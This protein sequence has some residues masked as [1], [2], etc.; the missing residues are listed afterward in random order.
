MVGMDC[1]KRRIVALRRQTH[2]G[3][4]A[5]RGIESEDINAFTVFPRVGSGIQQEPAL[6][7]ES[8]SGEQERHDREGQAKKRVVGH[9]HPFYKT[10]PGSRSATPRATSNYAAGLSGYSW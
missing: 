7:R 1:Q 8:I 4:L 2:G 6:G 9:H 3:E 10:A 5:V